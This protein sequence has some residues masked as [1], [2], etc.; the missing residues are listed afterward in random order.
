M[1]DFE[2][3]PPFVAGQ[4]IAERFVASECRVREL[5]LAPNTAT[6]ADFAMMA[7]D[8]IEDTLGEVTRTNHNF[9]TPKKVNLRG[10]VPAAVFWPGWFPVSLNISSD[11]I[12]TDVILEEKWSGL[13]EEC[14]LAHLV[15]FEY[16]PRRARK[17]RKKGGTASP[18]KFEQT[19]SSFTHFTAVAS[20]KLTAV[21]ARPIAKR[22]VSTDV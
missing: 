10:K 2:L 21:K 11:D 1:R 12:S 16:R 22:A 19:E 4:G 14:D 5:P 7:E 20:P 9:I 13:V 6:A 3:K 15:A 18:K 8:N 17:Q